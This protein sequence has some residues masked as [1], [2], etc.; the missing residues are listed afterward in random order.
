MFSRIFNVWIVFSNPL[1]QQEIPIA[2]SWTSLLVLEKT[3]SI[4]QT[5]GIPHSILSLHNVYC[6][7]H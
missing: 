5:K 1:K 4:I 2:H 3:W 6:I 7:L